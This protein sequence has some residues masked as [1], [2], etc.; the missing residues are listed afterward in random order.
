MRVSFRT[1][2]VSASC[3]TAS[4]PHASALV[5]SGLWFGGPNSFDHGFGGILGFL[6]FRRGRLDGAKSDG[7]RGDLQFGREIPVIKPSQNESFAA[8]GGTQ[9]KL[10]KEA[11]TS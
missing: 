11:T 1:E 10:Q 8:E 2:I 7:Q 9:W 4:A 5:T 3:G 6:R